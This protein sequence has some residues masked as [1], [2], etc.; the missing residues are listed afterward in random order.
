VISERRLERL[1]KGRAVAPAKAENVPHRRLEE[2]EEL[3][4]V[5]RAAG[6]T[7]PL[8]VGPARSSLKHSWRDDARWLEE[9][10]PEEFGPPRNQP[11]SA[12]CVE[13]SL[14]SELVD[15]APREETQ[16]P[17]VAPGSS[18]TAPEALPAPPPIP[19]LPGSFWQAVLYS[20]DSLLSAADSTRALQQVADKLGVPIVEGE[21]LGTLR[22]GA[23]AKCC[24][25]DSGRRRPKELWPRCG[26]VRRPAL[27]RLSQMRIRV[28]Y[29]LDRFPLAV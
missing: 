17:P 21:T 24:E 4:R 15:S 20:T 12:S 5:A 3:A 16:C 8:V 26:E 6:H 10:V 23:C 19:P 18:Q 2:V 22:A 11:S 1:R 25:T 7:G 14:C 13:R 27:A 28:S 29:R 9:N